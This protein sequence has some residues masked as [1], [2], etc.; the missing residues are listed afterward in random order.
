[1][2]YKGGGYRGVYKTAEEGTRKDMTPGEK[3]A[4]CSPAFSILSIK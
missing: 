1:M 3:K 4:G 2:G